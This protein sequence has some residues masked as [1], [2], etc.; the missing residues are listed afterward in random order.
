MSSRAGQLLFIAIVVSFGV[1]ASALTATPG[2]AAK[3]PRSAVQAGGTEFRIALSRS[4]VRPSRLRL[5]FV[6]YGEDIHD[7]AIR[8]VGTSDVRNL[9]VARPGN[10]NVG[11]FTVKR[12]TYQLWCTISDHRARGMSAVLKVRR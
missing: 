5:E 2:E 4:H 11:R 9:G 12:G 1:A 10:R 7:L 6:N 3:S 8:R